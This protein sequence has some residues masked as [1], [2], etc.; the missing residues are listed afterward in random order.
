VTYPW[1]HKCERCGGNPETCR[2]IVGAWKE[3]SGEPQPDNGPTGPP[4]GRQG[5]GAAG[6]IATPPSPEESPL[7]QVAPDRVVLTHDDREMCRVCGEL[8][9]VEGPWCRRC[10][11]SMEDDRYE[12]ECN[13]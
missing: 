11:A 5:G 3:T 2:C 10:W 1:T 9:A 7:N 4:A 6:R 12:R 13:R 8:P